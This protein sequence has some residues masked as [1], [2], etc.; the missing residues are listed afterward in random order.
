MKK[1]IIIPM[2]LLLNAI[3]AR[4]QYD[5]SWT[6]ESCETN[7]SLTSDL[8]VE[9]LTAHATPAYPV[10]VEDNEKS[11][12][13]DGVTV[14][15]T[16][17]LSLKGVEQTDA[18]YLSFDVNGPCEIIIAYCGATSATVNRV[19][20]LSYGDTH[21]MKNLLSMVVPVKGVLTTSTVK[22]ELNGEETIHVGS[23]NSGAYIYG[24]YV[25]PI[26]LD[27][28]AASTPKLSWNFKQAISDTDVANIT[29]DTENWGGNISTYYQY[30]PY[31]SAD[32]VTDNLYGII[33]SANEKEV[34]YV[35]GLRFGRPNGQVGTNGINN[36]RFCLYSGKNL[37]IKGTDIGFVVPELKRGDIV[38]VNFSCNGN[39]K[40]ILKPTNAVLING[41]LESTTSATVNEATFRVLSDGYVG[42]RGTAAMKYYSLSVNEDI[43]PTACLLTTKDTDYYSL[44]L[45]YD[46]I[47]PDGITA[48]TA[49]LNDDQTAVELT[50]VT[51][52]VLKRNRG[53]IV[54]GNA[55]GTFTFKV[56][57]IMGDEIEG[58]KLKGV[59]VDT[60]AG[61][62]EA[63]NPGKTVIM[64]GLKD[65]VMG[66]R[67]PAGG[68]IE[69]NKAYL[70]A[71]T[72]LDKNQIIAIRNDGTTTGIGRVTTG[73]SDKNAPMFNL[74]GQR[75]GSNFKGIVL[76][77]GK[78]VIRK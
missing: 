21:N 19:L 68:K 61:D 46:A 5:K 62:I 77:N 66:F 67:R 73:G 75:V 33:L 3:G 69:A 30:Y 72:P 18:R 10:A 54:K 9:G 71:D 41:N 15:F 2:I 44:Y 78:K 24:I 40:S 47:I 16:K 32:E 65:G 38:K 39:T 63:A 23:G 48:Y 8:K 27:D 20:N 45:D 70:L 14:N 6:F 56:S 36:D 43:V 7:A 53:Y 52:T 25:K 34:E 50:E 4:A 49:A 31:F 22:Y 13:I 28:Y 37:L 74:A 51:G 12:V 55:V 29:D 64:L 60:E 1:Y 58:N 26:I 42:F 35:K 17:R 11:T 59:T 57:D 76:V